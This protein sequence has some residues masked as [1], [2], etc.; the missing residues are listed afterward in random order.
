MASINFPRGK[1]LKLNG[2]RA[3]NLDDDAQG[4]E[5]ILSEPSAI[6][7]ALRDYGGKVYSAKE[8]DTDTAAKLMNY[9][10]AIR[11]HFSLLT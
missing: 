10:V 1:R 5:H 2:I 4:G 7:D 9:C 11:G 3:P 6:Q 8:F